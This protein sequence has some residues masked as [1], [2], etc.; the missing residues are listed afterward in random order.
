ML[1][2]KVHKV[3]KKASKM[4]NLLLPKNHCREC[5]VQLKDKRR[6]V[7]KDCNEMIL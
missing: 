5:G 7:C 2:G 4:S 3:I 6:K 1:P